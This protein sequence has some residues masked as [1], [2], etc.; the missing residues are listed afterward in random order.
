MREGH[1]ITWERTFTKKDVE[2]FCRISGDN[3][4]HHII[5]D[6]HGRLIVQGLLTATLPTKIGGDLNVLAKKMEFNFLKPV[7]TGDRILCKVTITQYERQEVKTNIAA[8]VECFNQHETKVLEGSFQ[9]VIK[10][11]S[12]SFQ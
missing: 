6:E 5:P 10:H 1:I 9:G 2:D 12:V 7:F 4:K 8:R 11:S 3:G